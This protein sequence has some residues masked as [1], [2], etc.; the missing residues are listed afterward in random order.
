M[1]RFL[2]IDE[3]QPLERVNVKQTTTTMRSQQLDDL[4]LSLTLGRSARSRH[5]GRR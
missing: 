3:E 5:A 4:V 1:L 2:E